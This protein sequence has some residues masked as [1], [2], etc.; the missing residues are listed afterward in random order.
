MSRVHFVTLIVHR[1]FLETLQL[2]IHH[3]IWIQIMQTS[4]FPAKHLHHFIFC[5]LHLFGSKNL[6][7]GAKGTR[8]NHNFAAFSRH[9]AV[10]REHHGRWWKGE[11]TCQDTQ[12][13]EEFEAQNQAASAS[14]CQGCDF[15]S[16][17]LKENP[18]KLVGLK[19]NFVLCCL[20]KVFIFF[21]DVFFV[22]SCVSRGILFLF[23]QVLGHLDMENRIFLLTQVNFNV[24]LRYLK[25]P[26]KARQILG[27]KLPVEPL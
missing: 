19:G 15:G 22:V 27:T 24:T 7:T 1:Y 20:C 13:E 2:I 16:L 10:T 4:H 26:K 6:T 11:G 18:T 14:L 21:C 5:A 8:A 23:V 9:P 25:D 3:R 17:Q 12:I